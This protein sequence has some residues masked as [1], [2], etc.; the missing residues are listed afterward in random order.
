M[1]TMCFAVP[2]AGVFGAFVTVRTCEALVCANIFMLKIRTRNRA[3]LLKIRVILK[4]VMPR[5]KGLK[6][7]CKTLYISPL[8]ATKRATIYS[9]KI[10]VEQN[11]SVAVLFVS[12]KG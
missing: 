3:L 6:K 4:Y 1:P 8:I 10:S 2:G 9:K 12:P 7:G 11:F 5:K